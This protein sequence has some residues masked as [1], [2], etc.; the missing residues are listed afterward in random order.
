MTIKR[1]AELISGGAVVTLLTSTCLAKQNP[2]HF[3]GGSWFGVNIVL[4]LVM[5]R[6]FLSPADNST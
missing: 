2:A 6:S 5:R 1:H 3:A 4:L